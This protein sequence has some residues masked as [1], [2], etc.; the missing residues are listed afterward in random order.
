MLA[1]RG[2]LS[3]ATAF[4]FAPM[5]ALLGDNPIE[6]KSPLVRPN[7]AVALQNERIAREYYEEGWNRGNQT[8]LQKHAKEAQECA[9][10]WSVIGLV[11]IEVVAVVVAAEVVDV[12]WTARGVHRGDYKGI[13]ATGRRA[14]VSGHTKMKIVDG[15]I[16]SIQAE[17]DDNDL[18]RQLRS[19]AP[20]LTPRRPS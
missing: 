16:V 4:L 9:K 3:A 10:I 13:K 20:I 1:R 2:L 18:L 14:T 17:W 11:V 15:R 7:S 5:K 12:R 19:P 8:V 6:R